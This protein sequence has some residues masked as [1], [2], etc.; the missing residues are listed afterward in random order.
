M[1]YTIVIEQI[2]NQKEEIPSRRHPDEKINC[3]TK[4]ISLVLFIKIKNI[5]IFSFS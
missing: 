4:P 3:I 5:L 2:E 1:I